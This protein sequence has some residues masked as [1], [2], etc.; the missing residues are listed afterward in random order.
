VHGLDGAYGSRR[1]TAVRYNANNVAKFPSGKDKVGRIDAISVET[2]QL[3]WQSRLPADVVGGTVTYSV[4]GR[5]YIAVA[6]GGGPFAAIG[7]S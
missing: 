3:L 2:G 6:A 1:G 4:N 5:Q 7:L